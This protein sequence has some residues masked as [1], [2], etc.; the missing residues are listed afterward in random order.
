MDMEMEMESEDDDSM[1]DTEQGQEF[2]LRSDCSDTQPI[3]W[4]VDQA[5]LSQEFKK[6]RRKIKIAVF[7]GVTCV[8]CGAVGAI[9]YLVVHF[10]Q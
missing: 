6:R 4:R 8:I 5:E 7:V 1:L 9:I 2:E 10:L 3:V